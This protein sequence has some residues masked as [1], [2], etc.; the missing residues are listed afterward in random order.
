MH[1]CNAF[2][3]GTLYFFFFK[4]AVWSTNCPMA[5]D[6]PSKSKYDIFGHKLLILNNLNILIQYL[7][8]FPYFHRELFD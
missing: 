4:E 8:N 3:V 6:L 1:T 2:H 5:S 7:T